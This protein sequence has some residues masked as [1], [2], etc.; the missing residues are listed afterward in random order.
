MPRRSRPWLL[1]I[2]CLGALI[3]PAGA[4]ADIVQGTGSDPAGDT[5][6]G[7]AQH[8]ITNVAASYDSSGSIAVTI[9][10]TEAPTTATSQFA[11]VYVGTLSGTK[12]VLPF[13]AVGGVTDPATTVA[14]GL[15]SG[16]TSVEY[17]ATKA[18]DGTNIT[19]SASGAGFA[20]KGY[21]CAWAEVLASASTKYDTTAPVTLTAPPPP[22]PPAQPAP[23]ILTRAQLLTKALKACSAKKTSTARRACQVKARAKYAVP[24]TN[25]QKLAKA[26]KA[27]KKLRTRSAR[28]KCV[29]KARA[30]YGPA[31]LRGLAHRVFFYTGA[32]IGNY[33]GGVC[34]KGYTFVDGNWAIEGIRSDGPLFPDCATAQSRQANSCKPYT[35]DPKKKSGTFDGKPFTLSANGGSLSF[36]PGS[37]SYRNGTIITPGTRT[38]LYLKNISI[39]GFSSYSGQVIY[40]NWLRM[41]ADGRFVRASVVMGAAGDPAGVSTWFSGVPADQRGTYEFIDGGQVRLSY[42]SGEVVTQNVF[43]LDTSS[44]TDP[45]AAG[46]YLGGKHYWVPDD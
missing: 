44:S 21:N 42:E 14:V 5:T 26:V 27:C 8:D 9:S 45:A 25:A 33:C 22:P 3:L 24:L 35:F 16:D 17:P 31:P 11:I 28:A 39:Y 38:N 29:T 6:D 30:Q 12:C 43:V 4:L 13:G 23:V 1:P 19:L 34:W 41:G 36:G 10:F 20:G 15:E 46:L 7:V 37:L 32:D 2:L 40:R 18:Q